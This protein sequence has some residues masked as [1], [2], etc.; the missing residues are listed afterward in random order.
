[1][2]SVLRIRAGNLDREI[3]DPAFE[4]LIRAGYRLVFSL[5]VQENERVE[6][7][8]FLVLA[9]TGERSGRLE[10]LLVVQI[11]LTAALLAVTALR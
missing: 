8:V 3:R 10:M 5:P 1:M 9:R 2:I 11:L 7:E 6:P 4:A